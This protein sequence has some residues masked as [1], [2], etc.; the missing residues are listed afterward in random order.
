MILKTHYQLLSNVNRGVITKV[1]ITDNVYLL[2]S[3]GIIPFKQEEFG[4][5]LI[6][7]KNPNQLK[8]PET[9]SVKLIQFLGVEKVVTKVDDFLHI[10]PDILN[11]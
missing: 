9:A 11:N 10:S 2:D 6:D 8:E 7:S 3:P 1:K 4:L 5:F